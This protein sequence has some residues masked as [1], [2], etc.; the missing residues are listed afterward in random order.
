MPCMVWGYPWLSSNLFVVSR[1]D[2]VDVVIYR[3][4]EIKV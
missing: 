1:E 2:S 3:V 4:L